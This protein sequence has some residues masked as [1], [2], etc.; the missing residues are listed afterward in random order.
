MYILIHIYTDIAY[1]YPCPYQYPYSYPYSH[2]CPR[3]LDSELV[4]EGGVVLVH[5]TCGPTQPDD[6]PGIVRYKTYEVL[7]EQV[8]QWCMM[9]IM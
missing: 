8:R 7:K 2:P 5:P 4:K 1:P 3:A 6:I 9:Y